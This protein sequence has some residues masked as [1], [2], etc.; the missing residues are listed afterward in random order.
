MTTQASGSGSDDI[1]DGPLIARAAAVLVDDRGT[2]TG[3]SPEAERLLGHCAQEVLGRPI[4]ALTERPGEEADAE[5]F[6]R[7]PDPARCLTVVFR[8]R[9]G[10]P[11]RVAMSCR[12]LHTTPGGSLRLLLLTDAGELA[13]RRLR[14]AMLH[15]LGTQSTVALTIYGPDL[16]V[17]WANAAARKEVPGEAATPRPG[18]GDGEPRP[19]RSEGRPYPASRVPSGQHPD[20]ARQLLRRVLDTG[21]TVTGL[22]Y[23]GRIPA[24]TGHEHVWSLSYYRLQDADGRPL[25]V[26]EESVDVTDLHRAQQRL[27]LLNE[28][29]D[30]IGSTLDLE[31]TAQELAEILVPRVADFTAVDLLGAVLDGREPDARA[32]YRTG[33]MR[34][35]VHHSLREDLP[36]VVVTAGGTVGYPRGSPQWE[37]LA[38]GRPVLNAVLDVGSPWLVHDAVRRARM[39]ELGIHT[40]LVVPLRAR[41][42]TMGVATLMRWHDPDP[43][44][45]E[46]VLLVEELAARAAVCIDNARRFGREHRSAL[47]LQESLLPHELPSHAAVAAAYRYL[48]A[49]TVAGVGGDWF[50]VLPLACARVGLVVGDV[51]GHGIRAAATMGRLRTAVHTLADL[52]LPPEELLTHLDDL[53]TRLS[54]EAETAYPTGTEG[55]VGATCLYGVYDPVN[56]RATFARAGHPPPAL[57]HPDK[58]VEFLDIPAGPPLGVGGMPFEPAEVEIPEGCL[59]ALYTD[60]L[61]TASGYD[62]DIGLER[63]RFALAHPDRPLEEICDT[64]ER[65]LLPDRPRD[66][67]AFLVARPSPLSAADVASWDLAFEPAAAG[68]ARALTIDRLTRWRLDD[69]SFTAELIVSELVTNAVRHARGPVALRLIR[70]E[71]RIILAV[72]DHSNTSPHLRRA[73]LGEEGGRGLFLVAQ[74]ALRWGTRYTTDGKVIWAELPVPSASPSPST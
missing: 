25:G 43:F 73:R 9:A 41:G 65:T 6:L 44:S 57:A 21:E 29:S 67:V 13:E 45:A 24:D 66:D 68:R 46:D 49:D 60:G 55:I 48:P 72:L 34:R 27:A 39:R 61:I 4:T 2:V 36:E 1:G 70:T 40:H 52:D 47:T 64:M 16:R 19:G 35:V 14:Q 59:L 3:W 22:Q 58:P 53:V 23:R 37:S 26:C 51:V 28:A 20:S 17:T 11:L 69:L 56:R 54:E 32:A 31:R 62:P 15:G 30:L 63:L 33:D 18:R 8:T 74:F 50:D 7:A 10:R 42:V 38:S 71:N 5:W 12:A